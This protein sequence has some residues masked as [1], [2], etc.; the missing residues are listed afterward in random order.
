MRHPLYFG[1]VLTFWS[2]PI[3]TAG[4]FLFSAGGTGY[5]LV[6]ISFEERDLIHQ[7]GDRYRR[8]RDEVGML[9]PWRRA[10]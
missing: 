9:L 4:H 3:M 10:P 5:I 7:F 6:G 1:M 2:V 8:Y